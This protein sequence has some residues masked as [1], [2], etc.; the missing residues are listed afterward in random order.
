M[1]NKSLKVKSVTILPHLTVHRKKVR[2]EEKKPVLLIQ[3]GSDPNFLAGS[4][5][6]MTSQVGDGSVIINGS[7]CGI[8]NGSGCGK[9]KALKTDLI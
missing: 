6:V 2:R 8:I 7:G 5:S 3:I 4:G 9:N 1:Q